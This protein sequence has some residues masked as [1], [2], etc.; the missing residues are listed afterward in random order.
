M[1]IET[2]LKD[3]GLAA[4][5]V[6]GC[7]YI[8]RIIIMWL[9]EQVNSRNAMLDQRHTELIDINRGMIAYINESKEINK[10]LITEIRSMG[11]GICSKIDN[12]TNAENK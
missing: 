2:V 12:I 8:L 3:Y 7:A 1:G 11:E 10:E 5:V 4:G 9:L 6:V